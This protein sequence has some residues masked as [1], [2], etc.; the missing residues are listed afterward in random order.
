MNNRK[1]RT[2]NWT[3]IKTQPRQQ[4]KRCGNL[5]VVGGRTA[6]GKSRHSLHLP[7]TMEE[8][9]QCGNVFHFSFREDFDFDVVSHCCELC[10]MDVAFDAN[11]SITITSRM[12]RHERQF[13]RLMEGNYWSFPKNWHFVKSR[14]RVE[15]LRIASEIQCGWV[16]ILNS[17]QW[18]LKS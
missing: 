3:V 17:L 4:G 10:L 9:W 15:W 8:N 7:S 18:P 12:F 5:W 13:E 2:S 1:I 16:E 11:E 14:Y 6:E